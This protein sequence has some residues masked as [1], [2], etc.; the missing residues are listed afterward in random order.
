MTLRAKSD[1]GFLLEGAAWPAFL[2]DG[3][4]TIRKANQAAIALFGSKLESDS[5]MLSAL[6][7]DETQPVEQFL[8]HWERSGAAVVRLKLLGKGAAVTVFST[9]I[10]GFHW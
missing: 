8:A 7:A 1:S 10:S 6:W 9:Y 2:V 4:G 5:T 3:G